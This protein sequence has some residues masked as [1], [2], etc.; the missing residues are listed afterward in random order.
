M[1]IFGI[2]DIVGGPG[3]RI[4]KERL[5]EFRD[6]EKVDFVVGNGENACNGAGIRPQDADDL[7][8]AGIDVLTGGDHI[9]GKKEIIPY[10]EKC[11][12]LLR[13]AN[14]PAEQPGRG[15]CVYDTPAG[16]VGVLHVQLR[17]FMH[18]PADCPFKT[19]H[20]AI[21]E[22]S[23]RTKVIVVDVHGEATSEK[24]AM[25][26]YLDGHASFVFGT[27]THIQTAD[28]RVLPQGT[29]YITDLGMTGPYDSV[30]GRDKDIVIN[31][32]I[33]QIPEHFDVATDDPRIC[34]ALADIDP[35]TGRAASIRR[36][37]ITPDGVM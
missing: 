24:I 6:R 1:R 12:K 30:I 33:S 37:V 25:G 22:I 14:Y 35:S 19:A 29:A 18:V 8:A 10:I 21:E 4:L 17:V 13:P 26:W 27:H 3:R 23:K 9:W 16:P 11:D 2:G 15:F 7:F 28:D 34:G 31:K 36:V 20:A 32:F 5:R